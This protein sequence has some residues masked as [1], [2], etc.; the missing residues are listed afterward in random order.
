MKLNP[1]AVPMV[2]NTWG[3]WALSL[4]WM[5]MVAIYTA[6]MPFIVI[7]KSHRDLKGLSSST[8]AQLICSTA[9]CAP[10]VPTAPTGSLSCFFTAAI[11]LK[12]EPVFKES[13]NATVMPFVA[14]FLLDGLALAA[15]FML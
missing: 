7:G 13:A 15:S 14:I 6:A 5:K 10:C 1:L 9:S 12:A 2:W 3:L 11:F 4:A 8:Y